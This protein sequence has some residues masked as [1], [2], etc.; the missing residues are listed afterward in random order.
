[1]ERLAR[2][3][4]VVA[5]RRV[6]QWL[7]DHDYDAAATLAGVLGDLSRAGRWTGSVRLRNDEVADEYV[8][9]YDGEEWYVKFSVGEDAVAITVWSCCWEGAVH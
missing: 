9:E 3:G 6:V 8:A 2:Q 7:V 4:R 1:V 5:T